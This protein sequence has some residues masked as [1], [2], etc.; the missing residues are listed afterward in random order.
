MAA[1]LDRNSCESPLAY[2]PAETAVILLDYHGYTI[3]LCGQKGIKTV[4]KAQM[5]REWALE[6]GIT[7]LHSLIDINSKPPP[8]CKNTVLIMGRLDSIRNDA[9][10]LSEPPELVS[11]QKA[12]P[13]EYVVLKTAGVVSGLKSEGAMDILRDKGI[14]SLVVLGLATSGAVLRTAIAASDEGFVTTVIEDACWDPRDGVHAFLMEQILPSRAHVVRADELL[15][16]WNK[17]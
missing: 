12:G 15:G 11:S 8:Q 2:P 6:R 17:A 16:S 5:I 10:A 13:V 14:K 9:V 4:S 3:Q 1:I 7:V